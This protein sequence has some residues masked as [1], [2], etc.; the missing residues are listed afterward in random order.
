MGHAVEKENLSPLSHA[1]FD[2]HIACSGRVLSYL[3]YLI[4]KS[5]GSPV[6]NPISVSGQMREEADA[7]LVQFFFGFGYAH[8]SRFFH[9][10]GIYNFFG[11][12][13]PQVDEMLSQLNGLNNPGA[14]GRIGRQILSLV[15]EDYAV[16]LL[17]PCFEYTLSTLEIQ[18][19]DN[20]TDPIDLI[21]SMSQLTVERRRSG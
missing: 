12:S 5:M 16:I 3:A 20:I 14:R 15:Q 8:L 1:P 11:Y 4:G 6:V 18:F 10:D 17:A 21:Q 13:N 7:F 9:S 19:S 2:I